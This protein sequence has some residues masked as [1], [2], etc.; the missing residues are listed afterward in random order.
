MRS[1]KWPRVYSQWAVG[2][3]SKAVSLTV[4]AHALPTRLHC[5]SFIYSMQAFLTTTCYRQIIRDILKHAKEKVAAF[6]DLIG[7]RETRKADNKQVN[8][9]F[10]VR[11]LKML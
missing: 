4:K 11:I 8:I 6:M 5:F 2:L 1:S 10:N 9:S 7:Q 3:H